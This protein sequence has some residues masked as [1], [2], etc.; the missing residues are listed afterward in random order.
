MVEQY[1]ETKLDVKEPWTEGMARRF[2]WLDV[3]FDFD[4]GFDVDFDY[5][6]IWIWI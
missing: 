6:W 2:L 3:G 1:L 5:I 4:V